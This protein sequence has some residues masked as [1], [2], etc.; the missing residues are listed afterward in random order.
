MTTGRLTLAGMNERLRSFEG[1]LQAVEDQQAA[2]HGD[3]EALKLAD[4]ALEVADSRTAS[5]VDE[6]TKAINHPETGLIVGLR[7]FRSEVRNDRK[8]TRA[9]ITGAIAVLS[10]IWTIL[11]AAAPW[12]QKIFPGGN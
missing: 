1:R 4:K 12:L 11:L 7:E 2:A 5:A 8:V 3:H 9:Y 10:A 6:L